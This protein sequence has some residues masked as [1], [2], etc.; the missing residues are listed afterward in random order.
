MVSPSLDAPLATLDP[1]VAAQIDAELARQRNGLE[2]IA[3]ENHTA[4]A[5][6]AAQGSVLTNKYAEG[7]PGR[8]YYGGCEH[9]DAIEQLAID[10]V[11]ALFGAAYANVQPHSGAQANASVMH[12][13]IKPG[14][15]IMGLNLA[16]GG[17]LTHGMR[18]NFSG[19]LYNVVPYQVR[20]D[21][22][23]VDMADVERLALEHRPALIVAGWSAYAR[24]LDFAEF[25]R[26]ADLV[27]AYLMVDMAHF[28]GLVAAGL[29]PSPVPHAHVTTSTTHKTLAG[30]R[31]GIILSNDAEIA[32]KINS[33]VFPGQQ[34]GPLE[35]VIAGKAVAFKIAA[36]AEFRER[37]ERVLA[38]AR[39]LAERLIQPDVAAKGISV[40]SGGTDVHLVLVDLRNCELDG[41][42]AEDRLAA[43]DVTVNRNAVPFDP[44]PPMVTSGLRIGTPALATRGFG[45]E[46]FTEVADIIAEA[47]IAAP[48]D[49]L[50]GLRSRV[51]ALAAAHPLYPG[52]AALS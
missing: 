4:A 40:I 37:Q 3:S 1:E 23:Q 27:G 16:H 28:A 2:M 30:P 31:G 46:A 45:L 39:I 21:T 41:Q 25:R 15:T 8:R 5:V 42:Q 22:H 35:H 12:A 14:D 38:G 18:I 6:M 11:K 34:G 29:H 26:I 48:G 17:H 44:R 13:L 20:E 47:L 50:S 52:V 7:Y 33:A 32:K 19:R 24:Q 10:R 51:A 9:V 36:S 43:I 49:D